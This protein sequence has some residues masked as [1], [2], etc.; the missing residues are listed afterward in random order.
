[1]FA[2][3]Q[4]WLFLSICLIVFPL[5]TGCWDRLEIE[6]RGTIL[7]MAIDP[8]D[9]DPPSSITGPNAKS[10]LRGYRLTAQIAIPGRIPLGPGESGGGDAQRPVWVVSTTGKTVDDAMNKLQQQLADKIFLGQLRVI[11][12]NQKIA[13]SVGMHDVQD[14][15]RRNAEI[16]RLCWL[17]VS[18]GSASEAMEAAPKLER[19][20]TLYLVSTLDH[21]VTLGKLPDVFLGNYWSTLS[22]KG[23]DPVLPF[24]KVIGPVK[25]QIEAEGLAIFRKD[26]MVG[27]LDPIETGVY[28]E[29][30]NIHKS[31]YGVA[32]PLPG[33]PQHSVTFKA[34]DRKTKLRCLMVNGQPSFRA[35]TVVPSQIEERTGSHS[36]NQVKDIDQ[37]EAEGSKALTESQMKVVKKLQKL[38]A[39]ALGLGEVIRGQYPDYWLNVLKGSHAK[40]EE[41]FAKTPFQAHV[42][43]FIQRSGMAAK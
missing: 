28:M 14:F 38:H 8:I 3:K 1:M 2:K 22:D 7:G 36:V 31:G 25:D 4:K 15:F 43:V 39:D 41:Q 12:V 37:I 20:P 33:D 6:D 34:L 19:V 42:R 21:A 23:A 13:R 10:D 17:I 27:T 35:S 18:D 24:I 11:T 16:R 5:L 9:G 26:R 30:K 32:L 29:L 40:W